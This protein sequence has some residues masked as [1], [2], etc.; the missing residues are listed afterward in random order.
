M[1]WAAPEASNVCWEILRG[2]GSCSDPWR[3]E[4]NELDEHAEGLD[5]HGEG[6]ALTAVT[7]TPTADIGSGEPLRSR[8]GQI[9]AAILGVIIVGLAVWASFLGK[10]VWAAQGKVDQ[11]DAIRQAAR[12]EA[13]N[14]MSIDYRNPQKAADQVLSGT[15]GEFKDQWASQSKV[16][17]DQITKAQATSTVQSDPK[18]GIVSMDED[19]AEAI[20]SVSS[21]VSFP[22]VKQPMTR[23]F[24]FSMSLTRSDS[25]WLVS[26]LGMVP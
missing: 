22:K 23:D 9:I 3:D 12:Q 18:V 25:R 1:P 4:S 19:S 8:R 5:E 13:V 11:R 24:R 10:D 16:F 15:T 7:E 17:V 20:V 6:R 2:S 21:T 14:L 26:K